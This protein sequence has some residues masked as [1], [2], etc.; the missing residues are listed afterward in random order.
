MTVVLAS[1]CLIVSILI[2]NFTVS[3]GNLSMLRTRVQ[4][5]ADSAALA[6]AVERTIAGSGHPE[7][8]ARRYAG[9]NG[10]EVVSCDCDGIGAVL[11]EAR[12]EGVT[13]EARAVADPAG[14]GPATGEGQM[15]LDPRLA[16]AIGRVIDASD[17]AV[18]LGSG[19]RDRAEQEA[20][21]DAALE[22]YGDPE[23]ADD[24]VARPGSSMH[25][26]GLAVDLQGDVETAAR[27]VEELGLPLWRPMAY[28]PWHFEL[29]GSRS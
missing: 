29:V 26:L 18:Q 20:L 7:E 28:E 22:R 13:A 16:H 14:F 15:A 23:I 5:A 21:W 8:E 4:I 11:V 19:V 6:A 25:E 27:L 1:C 9:L 2:G 12:I 24:W 3:L 10:A 17:G